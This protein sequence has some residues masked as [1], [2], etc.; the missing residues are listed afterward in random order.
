MLQ[1][2]SV[3]LF[4]HDIDTAAA[5]Y[6]ALATLLARGAM[7]HRGPTVTDFGAR[8][9]LLIDPF[10]NTLGLT[11]RNGRH[12]LPAARAM[13]QVRIGTARRAAQVSPLG[14]RGRWG[15][16]RPFGCRCPLGLMR[17]HRA[18]LALDVHD[19]AG[20]WP[21]CGGA[22]AATPASTATA[23]STSL[24]AVMMLST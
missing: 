20:G 10:G 13:A 14:A 16:S 1:L 12:A 18:R 9:A 11:R 24:D 2:E 21:P 15:G 4:V 7:L 8:V 3:A 19:P 5:W 6:A 17:R 23:A 22:A